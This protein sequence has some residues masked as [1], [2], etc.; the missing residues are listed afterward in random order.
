MSSFCVV[1]GNIGTVY[2]G[3][4][5]AEAR[6]IY[7]EYETQSRGGY[8]RAAGEPVALLTHGDEILAEHV[9]DPTSNW[10]AALELALDM[11][12][13]APQLEPTSALKQAGRDVGI[14]WGV[15]MGDFVTWAHG[16]MAQG[17]PEV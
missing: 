2:D 13:A 9:P 11:M 15:P 7:A 10:S 1:V 16:R 12:R 4:D 6:S 8:G 17:K 3:D 5:E 14:E